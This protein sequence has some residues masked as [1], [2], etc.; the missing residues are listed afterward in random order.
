[1]RENAL[2]L[3]EDYGVD[4]VL[5]GHSHSYE[6][7]YLVDGHYG[8]SPTL[9]PSMILDGGDG[10]ADGDGAYRKWSAT[11]AGHLGAVYAVAG[12]SGQISG[13]TLNHPV[14]FVS[15][16]ELGSLVLD[17]DGAEL[18]AQ[19]LNSSGVVRDHFTIEKTAPICPPAPLAGCRPAPR[20]L[21]KIIDDGNDARDRVV[22]KWRKAL[23]DP[24]D[25][26]NP[27]TT[28]DYGLCVYDQTGAVLVAQLAANATRWSPR[29][30]GDG[31][32]YD[33]AAAGIAGIEEIVL[34]GGSGTRTKLLARG[35]GAKLAAAQG[36]FTLPVTAQLVNAD[37]G[38]CWQSV[39]AS[40]IKNTA[41]VFKARL[42]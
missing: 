34:K 17:V 1:M 31:F 35:E 16:N 14:K 9:L 36:P 21:L 11:P 41:G 26:G 22:A 37:N 10:A 5:T 39:F 20:A 25:F 33:D 18:T 15:L 6:R 24:A 12:S 29:A 3:L 2:P 27:E 23:A 8:L 30:A 38:I 19:F 40:P 28:A 32:E 13:G 7:S 42:P 4:L